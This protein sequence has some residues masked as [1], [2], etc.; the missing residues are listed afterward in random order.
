M[1]LPKSSMHHECFRGIKCSNWSECTEIEWKPR[2]LPFIC[3]IVDTEVSAETVFSWAKK[4]RLRDFFSR[5]H[6]MPTPSLSVE[7]KKEIGIRLRGR[8]HHFSRWG[9]GLGRARMNSQLPNRKRGG[10]V[11]NQH[12]S[13]AGSQGTLFFSWQCKI[14][15]PEIFLCFLWSLPLAQVSGKIHFSFNKVLWILLLY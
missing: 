5:P 6:A 13:L 3:I 9:T 7:D 4:C 2:L 8:K 11:S 15:I 10:T 14:G 12:L 1:Y